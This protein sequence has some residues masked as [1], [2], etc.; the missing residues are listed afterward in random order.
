MLSAFAIGLVGAGTFI[1]AGL[2]LPWLLGP[3]A[4]CLLAAL[5]GVRLRGIAPLNDAMRT[6]LGVAVGATL[7]PAV[8][9]S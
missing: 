7:T 4:A 6:I 2:P 9:S 8:W 1:F 3:I 5:A